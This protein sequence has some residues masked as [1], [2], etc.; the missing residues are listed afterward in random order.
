[1]ALA[2]PDISPTA[3]EWG[4]LSIKWYGVSYALGILL[5]L[6]YLRRFLG[7]N[8]DY[9]ITVPVLD[10][11]ITWAVLGIVVGGRLGYVLLYKPLD[12]L[13]HPLE[14]FKTWTGGMSFHG[15]I[16][17]VMVAIVFYARRHRISILAMMDLLAIS[18]PLGIFLG[19][20]ANFVNGE[21]YGR[22]TDMP[23][24][25]YFPRGG[26]FPRHPS[27][28][29]EAV[30]EGLLLGLILLFCAPKYAYKRGFL[31]GLGMFGYGVVRFFVEFFREPDAHIGLLGGMFTYGQ[32]LC[33]PMMI[34]GVY[35][36]SMG[37]SKKK[38]A[39]IES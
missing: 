8:P 3:F 16:L 34:G 38:D 21:L 5:S 9:P 1:M 27:Q 17:G 28:L 22:V 32:F 31:S 11:F 15:G 2:F 26:E 18:A 4:P 12:Y 39:T 24:G 10:G 35:L 19:R 6:F 7:K 13:I 20:I 36:M 14:I 29:Y 30:G 23:W 33:L 37:K 25:V